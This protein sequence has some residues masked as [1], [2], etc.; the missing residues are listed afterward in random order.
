M[1]RRVPEFFIIIMQ[2]CSILVLVFM[3]H[4]MNVLI[5]L[6]M[7]MAYQ[8]SLSVLPLEGHGKNSSATT[9]GYWLCND[10]NCIIV[11]LVYFW[12]NTT[13]IQHQQNFAWRTWLN[14]WISMLEFAYFSTICRTSIPVSFWYW[15]WR[16]Y[17]L[18]RELTFKV[19]S[20]VL[21]EFI[22][23]SGTLLPYFLLSDWKKKWHHWVSPCE[24]YK[25]RWWSLTGRCIDHDFVTHLD[26]DNNQVEESK[27]VAHFDNRS[28]MLI[29]DNMLQTAS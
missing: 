18:W 19:S 11:S 3:G 28:A 8:P 17:N 10:K 21:K 16:G 14:V 24:R 13:I 23:S 4:V 12:S 5:E 15:I 6:Y 9:R 25:I 7:A 20:W 26:L 22:R 2:R 27:S 1:S 29:S